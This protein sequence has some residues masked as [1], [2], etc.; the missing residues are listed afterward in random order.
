MSLL[1]IGKIKDKVFPLP[2]SDK[3]SKSES[4]FKPTCRD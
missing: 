1:I 2:V 4:H 3:Q